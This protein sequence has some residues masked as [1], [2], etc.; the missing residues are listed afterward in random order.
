MFFSL[1]FQFKVSRNPFIDEKAKEVLKLYTE[2]ELRLL[3]NAFAPY[4]TTNKQVDLPDYLKNATR[5]PLLLPYF[6]DALSRVNKTR[7]ANTT[8][9]RK[10]R[11]Q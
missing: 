10:A 6:G 7:A 11:P 4:T 9:K 2:L 8:T 5:E 1:L 3:D